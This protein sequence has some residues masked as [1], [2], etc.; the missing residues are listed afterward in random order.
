MENY[1]FI[2][3]DRCIIYK[4]MPSRSTEGSDG[5]N[6]LSCLRR[7]LLR[8]SLFK[9]PPRDYPRQPDPFV[10]RI[11]RDSA[12]HRG[13]LKYAHLVQFSLVH[14][15]PVQ[16]FLTFSHVSFAPIIP[17]FSPLVRRFLQFPFRKEA[18]YSN[19]SGN[20]R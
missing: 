12:E 8:I 10:L 14:G 16:G 18:L 4:G 19:R 3:H 9:C 5:A 13:I 15:P 20:R 17:F 11:Q 7:K 2:S 1:A 6:R